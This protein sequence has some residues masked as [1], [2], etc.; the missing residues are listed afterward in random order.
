MFGTDHSSHG[1]VSLY[2]SRRLPA[3][4]GTGEGTV[5]WRCVTG[6]KS[7]TRTA[8]PERS[9]MREDKGDE[10]IERQRP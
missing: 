5:K 6:G 10:E 8:E 4:N 2:D 3:S 9:G 7:D 1:R